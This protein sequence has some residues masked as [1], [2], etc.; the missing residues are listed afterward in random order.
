VNN[1]NSILIAGA[2]IA[3]LTTALVLARCGYAVTVVESSPLLS[4]VGAGIQLGPNATRLLDMLGLFTALQKT[5][6]PL[7]SLRIQDITN[8]SLITQIDQQVLAV[9]YGF[10]PLC[11]HRA[12]LQ[13]VLFSACKTQPGVRFL[14]GKKL[15]ES[16]VT[17]EKASVDFNGERFSALVAADGLWSQWRS[18]VAAGNHATSNA[19]APQYTGKIAF[20]C[21]I[22]RSPYVGQYGDKSWRALTAQTQ[23]WL[24][25]GRHVVHYPVKG[26]EQLNLI[27]MCRIK[28][29]TA[30]H[31][32]W[33]QNSTHEF[34]LQQ[35]GG[36]DKAL[37]NTLAQAQKPSFW[38][39]YDRPTFAPYHR[40][41][42]CLLGD[43]AHPMQPH[44]AQGASLAIEDAFVLAKQL[45]THA[46]V[47]EAFI[48][49]SAARVAR[50]HM[51]QDKARQYGNIYQAG[52]LL[53][54]ARNLFLRSPFA[55]L[56]S[57]G[58]HWLY[59]GLK[60]TDLP[61]FV[62]H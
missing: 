4:E 42:V 44:L 47:A 36:V 45:Q 38:P 34:L 60:D 49:F 2:G 3:G 37:N 57:A 17:L 5:A 39:L 18:Y 6:S 56:N 29:P 31:E 54:T 58:M 30:Q 27:A 52:P 7:A 22:E 1:K 59:Q 43:A 20:R 46:S 28:E 61:R 32:N 51:A 16:Q 25:Y 48:G 12:D 21:L 24:G 35:F 50:T 19:A 41:V 14:F 10:A 9:R 40:N 11:V 53:S 13:A 15:D 8:G 55:R 26:G 62:R 23:L 33:N